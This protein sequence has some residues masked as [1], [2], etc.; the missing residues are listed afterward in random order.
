MFSW[1]L[2]V[3]VFKC[4]VPSD[5]VFGIFIDDKRQL[6]RFLKKKAYFWNVYL[7]SWINISWRISF[8][9]DVLLLTQLYWRVPI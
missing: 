7:A 9:A 5:F 6:K 8:F 1:F 4:S 2:S 3:V